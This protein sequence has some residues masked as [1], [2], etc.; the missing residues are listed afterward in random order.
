MT[1]PPRLTWLPQ[2]PD[3]RTRLRALGEDGPAA[4]Q[5]LV[6]LA[7][8]DLD[9]AAVNALDTKARALFPQGPG[10]LAL[11][12]PIRV[13]VLGSS[14]LGH[15]L[16]SIRVGGLRRG[17]WIETYQG[18][19]GQYLQE[20]LDT[21]SPLHAFG[22]S[23]IL[24]AYDAEHLTRGFDV[25]QDRAQADAVKEQTLAEIAQGWSL[26]QHNFRC[27]VIQQTAMPILD[28]LLG[29]NEH[30]LPGSPMAAISAINRGLEE[31]ADAAGVDLLRI[32][33]EVSRHGRL[34]WHDRALWRHAKQEVM[35]S[36]AP[37][38]GD[39][40]ARLLAAQRG[41]SF[42]C[43]VLDLD[44]TLWGGV[45][46]DDG[47]EG[48]VL[49]QG[50]ARGEG[51]VSVQRYV[52]ALNARGVILA[53]SSKNDEATALLPFGGHPDM[54]LSRSDI[55][56]F[57]ANWEDKATN[58]RAI[59]SALNIGLEAL[60]FLDDNP[61]EREL[62]RRELPMVAV[63]EAPDDP[64]LVPDR[65]AAAGYF[66]AVRVTQDDLARG[67]QYQA[68]TARQAALASTADM[69]GYLRDLD[70]RLI[71]GRFDLVNLGRITQLI[72]KTNQFNLTTQRCSEQE[73]R[74]LID[75]PAA[76]GLY[77]RLVDRFGDNG[78]I[79]VVIGRKTS[80]V[81][82]SIDAW[83]MS[84]R[85]LGRKVEDATLNVLAAQAAQMGA[86]TLIGRY[87]RTAKNGMV[88]DHYPRLGFTACATGEDEAVYT[89]SLADFAPQESA[90]RIETA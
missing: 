51:F 33:G 67:R 52:K 11:G 87:I 32:D 54:I 58:I 69:A 12:A 47:L 16:A 89:L 62:V 37:M 59:A 57:R 83:L 76:L 4:W 28:P 35:S 46:G 31:A 15:L 19:Y 73:V 20:L 86:Q 79:A 30:R 70:M 1:S 8:T 80:P 27:A 49:G 56:C 42:K 53:V 39:L 40:V 18:A 36:A 3:W 29:Q 60:V 21:A 44:N 45:I 82:M 23:A 85:V 77:L 66:E 24:F 71:W 43:L 84:C 88:Q 13:A 6:A 50:S 48:L 64:A 26:A 25:R 63:P 55:A 2:A 61:F 65:L 90:I 7:K 22:P 74:D 41:Q 10:E 72:N 34:A 38:Y 78:L 68:N 17:L 9:A 14:S 75:D 81:A 5:E